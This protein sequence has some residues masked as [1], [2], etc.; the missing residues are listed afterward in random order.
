MLC[1][2]HIQSGMNYFY[3][4]MVLFNSYI[5]MQ[6]IT[7]TWKYA[8]LCKRQM[9]YAKFWHCAP[10]DKNNF[11]YTFI[12]FMAGYHYH[13]IYNIKL[14][15]LLLLQHQLPTKNL[16]QNDLLHNFCAFFA[17]RFLLI[18]LHPLSSWV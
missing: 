4:K 13:V 6:D 16:H 3:F 11:M 12:L 15:P 1:W 8:L 14:L 2:G 5:Y 9:T 7:Y 10:K 17:H 18:A